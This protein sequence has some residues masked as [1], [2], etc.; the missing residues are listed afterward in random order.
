MSDKI[1]RKISKLATKAIIKY[2]M[3]EE[4]DRLLVGLSGGN[5]S[6]LLMHLLTL[7]Q[8]RAKISF[9]VE[10]ITI[11][12]G[13]DGFKSKVI[14]AYAAEQNWKHSIVGFDGKQLLKEK[15]LESRPCSLCARLR[16]GKIHQFADENRCNKIVLGHHT[17]DAC[18]SF[19]IG[20]FRGHGLTTMG[21]NV[22]AD[23]KS[24]GDK[25]LIRPLIMVQK[26]MIDRCC[27]EELALPDCGECDYSEILDEE[28]DRAFLENTLRELE[29]R[30]PHIR[31]HML[32]SLGDVRPDYLLDVN[33]LDYLK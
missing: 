15:G 25:R 5:D 27:R 17:D 30:F 31:S 28:G 10:A 22:A 1:L 26:S 9:E 2:K 3:I 33:F 7:L 18:V 24:G 32:T 11:D 6:M 19:L 14:A 20:L 8:R 16:R 23:V 12:A 4:G 29:V 13:F 21:P